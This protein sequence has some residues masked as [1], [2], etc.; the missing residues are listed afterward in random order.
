MWRNL[1]KK[2]FNKIKLKSKIG[3]KIYAY[4]LTSHS[5]RINDSLKSSNDILASKPIF[6]SKDR[7]RN[8]GNIQD[9]WWLYEAFQCTFTWN[10]KTLDDFS[11]TLAFYA[12]QWSI[13]LT[14]R[15]KPTTRIIAIIANCILPFQNVSETSLNAVK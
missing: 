1:R 6:T 12:H 15:C 8:T 14:N 4:V 3:I 13:G 9:D 2:F 10:N 5:K 11:L 7:H